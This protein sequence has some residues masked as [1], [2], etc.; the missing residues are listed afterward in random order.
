MAKPKKKYDD[1][2]KE[3]IRFIKKKL[4]ITKIQ[5]ID[6]A[7]LKQLKEALKQ[8]KDTRQKGKIIFKLRDVVMCVVL[9]SF[10][11]CNT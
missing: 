3:E 9:A 6:T 5:D 1:L 10:A 8:L 7:I 2:S 4:N 11:F